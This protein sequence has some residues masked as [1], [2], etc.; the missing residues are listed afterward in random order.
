MLR[1]QR[2]AAV[3]PASREPKLGSR[4]GW[5]LLVL[6]LA[7]A[8]PSYSVGSF[9]GG[10]E[11]GGGYFQLCHRIG[12]AAN[13]G[14]A[15]PL[16]EIDDP[17]GSVA[18]ED[19][20]PSIEVPVDVAL[21]D[22]P[23]PRTEG[24]TAQSQQCEDGPQFFPMTSFAGKREGYYFSRGFLGLGYYLDCR[25]RWSSHVDQL[26]LLS[27]QLEREAAAPPP[28][29]ISLAT[30]LGLHAVDT[31]ARPEWCPHAHRSGRNV[32]RAVAK[33]ERAG[34]GCAAVATIHS[35]I[36]S[37]ADG[38]L[39]WRKASDA[40]GVASAMAA[41]Q[42]HIG[43][44]CDRP[45]LEGV[46]AASNWHRKLGLW[47]FDTANANTWS[48]LQQ[49]LGLTSADAVLAQET[50]V[51]AG[52]PLAS[53]ESSL[54]TNGWRGKLHQCAHGPAGG[55]SAG[56]AVMTRHY[57]GMAGPDSQCLYGDSPRF[58]LQK[59][60][61]GCKGGMHVGSL[62]LND[63]VGPKAAVNLALL[64]ELAACLR[65]IRGPWLIGATLTS[66]RSNSPTRDSSNWLMVSCMPPGTTPAMTS[67]TT[68]SLWPSRSVQQ[69]W[70]Y[71]WSLTLPSRRI[72]RLDCCSGRRRGPCCCGIC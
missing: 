49:Y 58:Q 1:L 35:A 31:S 69:S 50:K 23:A 22:E 66:P 65:C 16:A 19:W 27:E 2:S 9:S 59:V 18:S 52:D 47:A 39:S 25:A 26:S 57:I 34:E 56:T 61:I 13:P 64:E 72:T 48:T 62:Y 10:V 43:A 14:P 7:L 54:R 17:E 42:R 45:H 36:G 60:G 11:H 21:G 71:T 29:R 3:D 5:R 44:D 40:E 63:K 24:S 15:V 12:E 67:A 55:P 53:S 32:R 8:S 38:P 70:A 68:S 33:L 20:F 46:L 30:E 4:G 6:F 41:Y 37:R 51:E 28:V